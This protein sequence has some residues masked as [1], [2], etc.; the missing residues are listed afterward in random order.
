[1]SEEDQTTS[2]TPMPL[3]AGRTALVVVDMQKA[4][5]DP[6]GSCARLGLPYDALRTAIPGVKRLI[7]A[8]RESGLPIIYT[9][10]VYR[11]DYRDGGIVTNQ[12]L[13]ALRETRAL[14]AGTADIEIIDELT[15]QS[16][17]IVIDKNRPG[18]FHGTPLR[19]CLD[20]LD[21]NGL[22]LCGV[23][24]NVCVETTAREAMQHDFRVWVVADATAEFEDDRHTVALKGL[25]WMFASIV[26][27]RQALA[28]ISSLGQT[29]PNT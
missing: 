22:I 5:L 11:D 23:T 27:S 24:T 12:L 6:Q 1:M 19:S 28:A 9:R 25:N 4:F 29:N 2:G 26:E 21:A 3:T 13:P 10:F 18:A 16:G 14:A 7:A 17:D 20:G 8:A 15:P